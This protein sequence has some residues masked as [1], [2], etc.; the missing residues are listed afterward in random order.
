MD[1]DS[2]LTGVL[3]VIKWLA[4]AATLVLALIVMFGS[5]D[6][7]AYEGNAAIFYPWGFVLTIVYFASAYWVLQ[8]TKTHH[9]AST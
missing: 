3:R 6:M 1:D 5:S 7:E 8:R 4:L 9:Q 2:A